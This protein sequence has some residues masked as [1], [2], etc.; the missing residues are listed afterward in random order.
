MT[1]ARRK[2]IAETKRRYDETTRTMI[3]GL[4]CEIGEDKPI[5]LTVS[6]A[7][8]IWDCIKRR[9]YK[10]AMKDMEQ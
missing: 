5:S 2:A 10:V 4:S 1:D 8:T 9:G 3:T 6:T 7:R